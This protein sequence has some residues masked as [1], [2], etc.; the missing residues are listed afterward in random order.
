MKEHVRIECGALDEIQGSSDIILRGV[1]AP[2]TL[3]LIK[4]D[5][6]QR[7]VLPLSSVSGLI[8]AIKHGDKV[9]DITL[10]M[11]GGD[12]E[13]K[14][15]AYVLKNDVFVIDGLQRQSVA[16]HLMCVGEKL[17]PHLGCCVYFNTSYEGES[18]LFK[19]LNT[20]RVRL[21]P[22]ILIRNMR[23]K[24][25][26]VELIL[27]LCD[28]TSFI[29]EDRVCWNQRM[30]RNEL[31][32]GASML[33]TVAVLHSNY[34]NMM[35]SRWQDVV[36]NLDILLRDKVR[37]REFGKNIRTFFE[38]L[39]SAY[40]I[41]TITYKD[42]AT[43]LRTG[44]LLSL[45]RTLA[46]HRNFWTENRELVVTPDIRRKLSSFSLADPMVK[47]IAANGRVKDT[48]VTLLVEHLNSGKRTRRL[49][50]FQPPKTAKTGV[51]AA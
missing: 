36:A 2:E 50:R 24:S 10:G 6:Y 37:R 4:A 19:V 45:A 5:T 49:V 35:S 21:S 13:E 28:D 48:L 40:G 16:V 34:G 22:N 51:A 25:P 43:Y 46:M 32:N 8:Q 11:R 38:V 30:R 9:P 33:H 3:K 39:D 7:E 23:E 41:R 29:L 18:E 27:E 12:F 31:L 15:G 14:N 1:I 17:D 42:G 20:S 44:F 26:A 47:T